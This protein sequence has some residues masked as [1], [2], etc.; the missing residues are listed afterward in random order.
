MTTKILSRVNDQVERFKSEHRGEKPLYI[1]VSPY[2]ADQLL[3]EV[4]QAAGY[5]KDTLVTEYNGSKIVKYDAL[6][7]GDMQLTDELPEASG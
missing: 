3:Q 1:L 7:K 6:K 5:S 2:E 4:K